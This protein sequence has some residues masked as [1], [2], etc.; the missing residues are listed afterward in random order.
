MSLRKFEHRAG[1]TALLLFIGMIWQS[2]ADAV[3]ILGSIQINRALIQYGASQIDVNSSTN[4]VYFAGGYAVPYPWQGV[5]AGLQVAD[6]STVSAPTLSNVSGPAG[7]VAVDATNNRFFSSNGYGGSV[8]TYNGASNTLMQSTPITGCGSVL[9]F[10]NNLGMLY[11]MTQCNDTLFKYNPGTNTVVAQA[12][13]A[14]VAFDLTVNSA[15]GNVYANT[16]TG[17]HSYNANLTPI[18]NGALT[19][20]IRAANSVTN[21]LYSLVGNDIQV[22]D[23]TTY[24]LI[25][26]LV[27]AGGGYIRADSIN[28]IFYVG[29]SASNVIRA[30][31]GSTNLLIDSLAL[32]SS[33]SLGDITTDSNGRVYVIGYNASTATLFALGKAQVPEP[34]TLLLLGMGFAG[35]IASRNKSLKSIS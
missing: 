4:R 30:Y 24:A 27:N 19:G 28:N 22:F 16:S 14:S 25:A 7:G 11:G 15:T 26:T 6:F 1:W 31:D 8:L 18:S 5:P 20:S 12:S 32:P 13:L 29:S 17:I 23:G 34:T 3:P 33:I 10:N 35:L 2:S 9:D 21:R